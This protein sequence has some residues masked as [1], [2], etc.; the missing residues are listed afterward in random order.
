MGSNMSHATTTELAAHDRAL[1][2]DFFNRCTTAL[3][4]Q[5]GAGAR[6]LSILR[7][8]MEA[9]L[10]EQRVPPALSWTEPSPTPA[11][12]PAPRS[13]TSPTPRQARTRFTSTTTCAR[14]SA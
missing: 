10:R 13:S 12:N 2:T 14:C 11:H 1:L 6:V 8:Q 4:G 7:D 3:A 5:R 9:T